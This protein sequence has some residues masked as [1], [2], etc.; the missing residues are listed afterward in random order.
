MIDAGRRGL[1]VAERGLG[2]APE[3]GGRL[4]VLGVRRREQPGEHRVLRL[5]GRPGEVH[6]RLERVLPVRHRLLVAQQLDQLGGQGAQ[7]VGLEAGEVRD[8]QPAAPVPGEPAHSDLLSVAHRPYSC[9]AWTS[10]SISSR[11]PVLT[12]DLPS[13]C[14]SIISFS[15]FFLL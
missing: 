3:L 13:W 12:T 2:E 6:Q 11:E 4:L 15:A 7:Q 8:H 9:I 5:G 10:R 1:A 14:T